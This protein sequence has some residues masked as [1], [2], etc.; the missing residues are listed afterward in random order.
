MDYE[1]SYRWPFLCSGD[2]SSNLFCCES[3]RAILQPCPADKGGAVRLTL[4][5]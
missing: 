1:L 5:F 3:S 2:I 4:G